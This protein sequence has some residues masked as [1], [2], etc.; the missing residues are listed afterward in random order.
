M[1]LTPLQLRRITKDLG[2]DIPFSKGVDKP[3]QNCW[4]FSTDGN[5]VDMMFYDEDDFRAGM[6]R[7]YIVSKAYIVII[8]AFT[9]MDTHIHFVLYGPLE[10]C[11]RFM[12]DFVKRTSMYMANHHGESHK[13]K[14]VPIHHQ[15]VDTDS[16]LKTVICYVVRNA[17]VGGIRFTGCDYPWSSGPLYFRRKG[18]WS[19]PRWLN[20]ISERSMTFRQRRKVLRTSQ[21]VSAP[22]IDGIVFPGEYVAYE[23]VEMLFRSHK[24]YLFF[25]CRSKESDVD[26]R[27]GTISRLSIPMQEMRQYRNEIC[28]ELFGVTGIRHLNTSQRLRLAKT[29]RVRYNS[30]LK[31]VVR[32]SGLVYDEVKDYLT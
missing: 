15:A 20:N 18:Y 21:D 27:G 2:L 8:L 32:L 25:M 4:H 19:S 10:E 5:A 22:M 16:Y 28:R 9:L 23:I 17:P 24:A 11:R 7:V 13:L 26:S 6:N 30:S 14:D 3:I 29:L 12:H 31:Q 1:N